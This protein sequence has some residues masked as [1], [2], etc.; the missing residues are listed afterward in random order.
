[1]KE[2]GIFAFICS[3]K[4][5]KAKYGEK[6]RKLILSNQLKIY[7]DF[8]GIKIFKETSVDTCVIQIKKEFMENNQILV[9]DD[10]LMNQNRLDSTSFT[11]NPPEVLDLREKIFKQ[12]TIIKNLDIQI[13]YGIKT[14]FN[15]AFIIDEET[16]NKLIAEDSNNEEII[17][18]LL[19][20]K[21]IQKWKINYKNFY[22]IFTRRGININ[23]YPIIKDYLSIYKE[24][25][26]PKSKN[27][28]KT[29][30]G[31]KPGPYKWY[32]IQDNVAYFSSFE[33]EKIIYSEISKEPSFTLDS[34][35]YFLGNTAYILNSN[36]IN[37]KYLLGLLNSNVLFWIFKLVCYQLGSN[38]F[39]FIKIFVEQLPIIIDTDNYFYII[40]IVE[41]ILDLNYKIKIHE[42]N[43]LNILDKYNISKLSKKLIEFE[44]LTEKEF[45]EEIKNKHE[46]FEKIDVLIE[47]FN[48]ICFEINELKSQINIKTISLN[49]C[50]YSIYNLSEEEIKIIEND[51]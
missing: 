39:R 9:N 45:I 12:G 26:T 18:P 2:K 15:K 1:M 37:L 22:L 50:V 31:R 36:S 6:L 23:K 19:R 42:E 30:K 38:G 25:L 3:N 13:N 33:K 14:G 43:F 34:K 20:G 47:N 44:K 10:Y 46:N 4:F 16:K 29:S 40:K 21:D 28:N 41:D 24:D 11:F 17:K 8:T 51:L 49:K 35:N 27:S 5:A 32:E 7:N 48:R